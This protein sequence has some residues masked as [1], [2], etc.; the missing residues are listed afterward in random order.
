MTKSAD[1]GTLE[2]NK[3]IFAPDGRFSALSDSM[4]IRP[5]TV[6]AYTFHC[7]CWITAGHGEAQRRIGGGMTRSI[8][9]TALAC[10]DQSAA[11]SPLSITSLLLSK[12]AFF[13]T[14]FSCNQTDVAPNNL[15]PGH[16]RTQRDRPESWIRKR[17][18]RSAGTHSHDIY[19][20]ANMPLPMDA[21]SHA[22][23]AESKLDGGGISLLL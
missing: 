5:V 20:F 17:V 21:G 16:S 13:N 14:L 15:G 9:K 7:Q 4:G 2:G 8:C 10:Q 23:R 18:H 6:R 11:L 22:K 19:F 3:H 1:K 12:A